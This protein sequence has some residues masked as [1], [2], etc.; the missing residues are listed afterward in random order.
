MMEGEEGN[1]EATPPLEPRRHELLAAVVGE[2][3]TPAE[4]VSTHMNFEGSRDFVFQPLPAPSD[5]GARSSA[6][7]RAAAA[8][9]KLLTP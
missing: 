3:N 2:D 9:I 1:G 8:A 7:E 5:G 6:G 4:A